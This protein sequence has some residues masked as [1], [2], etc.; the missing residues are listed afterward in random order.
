MKAAGH[1]NIECRIVPGRTHGSIA[2][3]FAEA[4]DEVAPAMLEFMRKRTKGGGGRP[5]GNQFS[6]LTSQLTS[7]AR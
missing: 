2:G 4:N 7:T 3:K 6:Q 5:A 1:K